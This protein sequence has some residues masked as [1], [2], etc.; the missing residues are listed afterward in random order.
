M[1]RG[2]Y[3][4]EI[5]RRVHP[6]K[7][8]LGEIYAKE[9]N[10]LLDVEFYLGLSKENMHR[11]STW[12]RVKKLDIFSRFL[13]SFILGPKASSKFNLKMF[14]QGSPLSKSSRIRKGEKDFENGE[15]IHKSENPSFNGF[16]NALSVRDSTSF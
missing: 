4:N 12:Y 2:W 3:L 13:P 8:T 9:I 11:R 1:T 15:A 10:P 14:I 7:R 6:Q 16:T 5:V